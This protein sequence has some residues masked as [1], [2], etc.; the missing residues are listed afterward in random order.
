[1]SK[2]FAIADKCIYL[3]R[4]A[5]PYMFFLVKDV[6]KPCKK[7]KKDICPTCLLSN[8]Q[9][10]GPLDQEK[11]RSLFR[12]KQR[13]PGGCYL[14]I[15]ARTHTYTRAHTRT[16]WAYIDRGVGIDL[17]SFFGQFKPQRKHKR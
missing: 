17:L 13:W 4:R 2:L 7:K 6:Y 10:R 8:I 16:R 14:C 5:H 15:T 9:V 12:C 11:H 3:R 1:M